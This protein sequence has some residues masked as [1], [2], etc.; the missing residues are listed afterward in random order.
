LTLQQLASSDSAMKSA[1]WIFAAKEKTN[2]DYKFKQNLQG[3][4]PEN[5]Q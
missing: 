4:A 1:T 3:A 2:C 5:V